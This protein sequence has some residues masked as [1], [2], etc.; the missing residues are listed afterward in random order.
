MEGGRRIREGDRGEMEKR[1]A[2]CAKAR[3]A[4]SAAAGDGGGPGAQI[5]AAA[6]AR[7]HD[8]EGGGT[9]RH[10]GP[11]GAADL[12]DELT[13]WIDGMT[14]YNDAGRAFWVEAY[15]GR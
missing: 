15:G 7:C 9:A 5:A 3:R 4:R 10:S 13:G 12:A 8:R 2:R 11:Q 14:S 1:G 6:P